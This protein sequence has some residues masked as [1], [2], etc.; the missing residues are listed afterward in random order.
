MLEWATG[1]VTRRTVP[2]EV[3]GRP[4]PGEPSPPA[5]R[6]Q[7]W[8]S[9]V[10]GRGTCA[11]H[12]QWSREATV[13]DRAGRRRP[14]PLGGLLVAVVVAAGCMGGGLDQ[15]DPRGEPRQPGQE[16]TRQPASPGARTTRADG[17]TSVTEFKQDFNDAVGIAEQ[18]WTA[19]FRAS[20][21]RFQP[22]RRVVPYSR[23]GEVSCGGQALPRNNAVYCSAGD[24]IAYDVN[25][26]VSAFR[27]VGD[28]FLFYLLG[29]EY[30]H[31]VQVRL[32]IRY[33]FTIQQELQADC[34]AGAYIGDNVRDKVL[35]LDRGD[36]DEFREGLLAVGD[37]PDQ[38]WFAEGSH[39]TAEQRSDSFFRG[40]ER[41]LDA[42]GLD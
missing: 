9:S 31:G 10:R 28:A 25:W 29:H 27:Q 3:H 11:A 14:G 13:G 21:E 35:T 4:G 15:G 5:V 40:Y 12:R 26:S 22:I 39:G 36:L 7:R 18:Y 34:M 19:R 8:A 1:R 33:N 23:A 2:G 30:A 41:S 32:G 6:D 16:Q 20:G 17:T 42:C 37:D 24:F 38:P